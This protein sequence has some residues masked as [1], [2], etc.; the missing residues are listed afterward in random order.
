[1]EVWAIAVLCVGV[2]LAGVLLGGLAMYGVVR[3]H[4]R[5]CCKRQY[6]S[7]GVSTTDE[8]SAH[9]KSVLQSIMHAKGTLCLSL[10]LPESSLNVPMSTVIPSESIRTV[11]PQ[12][13]SP[14]Q[15]DISACSS[16]AAANND[17]SPMQ[18]VT[19]GLGV[20]MPEG[21]DAPATPA[22]S[23][24]RSVFVSKA[25]TVT[26]PHAAVVFHPLVSWSPADG[27]S[28][29]IVRAIPQRMTN[30]TA[31]PLKV[32][33]LSGQGMVKIQP[34]P[35]SATISIDEAHI[36]SISSANTPL[37]PLILSS[38]CD[39][40]EYVVVPPSPSISSLY[41]T[42]INISGSPSVLSPRSVNMSKSNSSP[43]TM[44]GPSMFSPPPIPNKRYP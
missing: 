10:Q 29:P 1:M 17:A 16:P 23:T 26:K 33:V 38:P 12:T 2:S 14:Q 18:S 36:E 32:S 8:M 19:S 6:D 5:Q 44:P 20:I 13:A 40:G 31:V 27:K 11:S 42:S 25:T 22:D 39:S 37:T 7:R 41:G 3:R 24:E 15:T 4:H 30:A 43:G 9:E 21:P 35:H 34:S 28:H